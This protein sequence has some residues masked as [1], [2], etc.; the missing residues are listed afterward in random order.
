[1]I[2][3]LERDIDRQW[4]ELLN[5]EVPNDERIARAM[6]A[7]YG[8]SVAPDAN[9]SLRISDGEVKTYQYNG[10]IAQPYTTFYG[11]Y[12]RTLGFGGRAPFD[13]PPRWLARRDSLNLATPYN[14]ISTNDIIGGSS[15]SPVLNRDGEIVGLI[16]D[17]NMESLPWRFRFTEAT[18]RSVWVDSR[19]IVEAMR[20]VYDAGPLADELTR[21]R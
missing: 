1:M 2:E 13:L 5:R 8:S 16:F 15:G 20:R 17:G 6:L 7:T 10:T 3:P 14:G 9:S 12:D 18:G 11:L 21:N 4:T 19:A